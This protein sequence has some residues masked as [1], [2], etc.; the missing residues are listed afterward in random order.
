MK[1]VLICPSDRVA[2][3]HL[4]ESV[5][6]SNV[7]I[8]G[9]SLLEYWLDHLAALG[10]R[11]VTVL[12]SDRPHQVRRLVEGGRRWGLSV[13]VI[14]ERWELTITEARAKYVHASEGGFLSE[15]NDA[16]L[17]DYLPG[18]RQHPLF[19]S[20]AGWFEAVQAYMWRAGTPD[21]IGMR[22][23]RPGIWVGLR[24]RVS[25]K[26]KLV[27]PC[28]LGRNVWVADEAIVGPSAILDNND[29]HRSSSPPDARVG[30]LSRQPSVAL[31][32]ASLRTASP[33]A[34]GPPS[35]H[36]AAPPGRTRASRRQARAR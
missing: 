13:E 24:S 6:L 1:A 32:R 35:P 2:V 7:P 10:A 18:L 33:A 22:E 28:W 34:V 14:P 36:P 9:K 16:I 4:A 20:Y 19:N 31:P 21:R 3:S 30:P 26:A 25:P 17:M 27:A 8:L 5:P 29:Q 12:C 11:E 15:P 23:I